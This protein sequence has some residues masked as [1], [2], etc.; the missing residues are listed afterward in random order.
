MPAQCQGLQ[1]LPFSF[2]SVLKE[3]HLLLKVSSVT[4][5]V[6]ALN[7]LSGFEPQTQG[8]TCIRSKRAPPY[9]S[10]GFVL[11]R[12]SCL[13]KRTHTK[14][15]KERKA[16]WIRQATRGHHWCAVQTLTFTVGQG[17]S[18]DEETLRTMMMQMMNVTITLQTKTMSTTSCNLGLILR[19]ARRR[20]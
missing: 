17:D 2:C 7:H 16:L 5:S 4:Y 8:H 11:H 3:V 19:I 10:Q 9:D 13:R 20:V 6:D 12:K 14:N 1:F 15:E 18:I